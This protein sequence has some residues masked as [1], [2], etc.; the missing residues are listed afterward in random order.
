MKYRYIFE[1]TTSSDELYKQMILYSNPAFTIA[2]E[3]ALRYVDFSDKKP[4]PKI[5]RMEDFDKMMDSG[6]LFARKFDEKV[7]EE[8]ID[9]V[10]DKIT[11]VK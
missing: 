6:C 4:S 1:Y 2:P 11:V 3:G 8:V 10:L 5:L 7:D 9:K